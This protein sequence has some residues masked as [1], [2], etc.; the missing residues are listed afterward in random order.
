MQRGPSRPVQVRLKL[1]SLRL[2]VINLTAKTRSTREAIFVIKNVPT[3][4]IVPVLD[5]GRRR[6]KPPY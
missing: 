3:F 6:S 4:C 5:I 2:F 1:V